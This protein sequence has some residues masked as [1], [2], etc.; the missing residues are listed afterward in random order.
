RMWE[1]P[2]FQAR[3]LAFDFGY[4]ARAVESVIR[5]MHRKLVTWMRKWAAPAAPAVC[6][7]WMQLGF[8]G[9]QA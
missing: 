5:A 2:E 4:V 1:S 8:D 7:V 6:S 9:M 3:Q